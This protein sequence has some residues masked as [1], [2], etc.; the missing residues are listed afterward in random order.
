MISREMLTVL[1]FIQ[2]KLKDE[3]LRWVVIGSANQALQGINIEP[4]DLDIITS[5][6]DIKKI[7]TIFREYV[8]QGLHKKAPLTKGY[9]DCL[10]LILKINNI[11]VD[12]IGEEDYDIYYSK[13]LKGAVTNIQA[14][15]LIIPCLKLE[16]ELRAYEETGRTEKISLIEEHLNKKD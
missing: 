14:E 9:P 5:I 2:H 12:I 6:K 3:K 13:V 7:L 11:Q 8:E 4:N 16:A 1:K 15:G 10:R